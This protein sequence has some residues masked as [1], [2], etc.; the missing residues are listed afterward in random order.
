MNII[1]KRREY[2][3]ISIIFFYIIRADFTPFYLLH[4]NVVIHKKQPI[5]FSYFYQLISTTGHTQIFL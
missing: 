1:K 2:V 3:D 5:M 4:H